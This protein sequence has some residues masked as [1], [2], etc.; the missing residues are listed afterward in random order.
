LKD[1]FLWRKLPESSNWLA[2][3][4]WLRPPMVT[5]GTSEMRIGFGIFKAVVLTLTKDQEKGK[6]W[7]LGRI[8]RSGDNI[9]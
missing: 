4:G 5:G 1:P 8:Q 3:T 7:K 9:D 6:K 2:T